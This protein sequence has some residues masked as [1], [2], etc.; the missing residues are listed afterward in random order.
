MARPFDRVLIVMFENQYRSYVL[1]DPFMRKLASAG[2]EMSSYF[3][4]FHPSQT[5]YV[6]SLAGELCG[7]TN[8]TPPASPLPQATLV[9][10]M[11][12][13]G[14]PPRASWKAY[15]E[16]YPGEPWNPVWAQ[17][18]YPPSDQPLNEFPPADQ[19]FARYYRKHN[20]FASFHTIQADPERWSRIVS[21]VAFWDDVE[22]GTW[23]DYGWFTPDIWND[24]HY[25]YNTHVD[26][27]PRM[28]LIGQCAGWLEYVFLG[29]IAT[30]DVR[31]G[32]VY[33]QKTLGLGLDVDLVLSDPA[34]AYAQSKIP[35]GTLVVVTFDEADY[36]ASSYDTNYDGPNQI[37]TVLL[38]DMIEPGSSCATPFN[39]Y[40]LIKTV[41][42]TFDLG[43]L[44]KN[45]QHANWFRCL[46]GQSFGWSQPSATGLAATG[47]AIAAAGHDGATWLLFHGDA[48]VMCSKRVG[49]TWSEA[50]ATGFAADGPLAL[51]STGETLI[52]VFTGGGDGSLYQSVA[53]AGGW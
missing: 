41:E 18:S 6:A 20:A 52:A 2:C 12:P 24:G 31:G 38:G 49:G 17:Q 42:K 21:D 34:K 51:A 4:A 39:H 40:S 35:A 26:T 1:K 36:D 43:S 53:S 10:L 5:N 22:A 47:D 29:T 44:G 23:P 28:P 45:D 14:A 27:D 19:G 48:G 9:D 32:K 13:E 8:D 7:V 30:S 16:A 37:Y 46:W 11:Q 3:G 33:H 15:M 25:L 50:V